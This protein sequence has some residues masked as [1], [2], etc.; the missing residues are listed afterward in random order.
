MKYFS[1]D[2]YVLKRET[3]LNNLHEDEH[4]IFGIYAYC[5]YV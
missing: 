2:V 1:M 3:F 4:D 5:T